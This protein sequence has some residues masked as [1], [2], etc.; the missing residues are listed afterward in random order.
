MESI[1]EPSKSIAE[2]YR[3]LRIV[4]NDGKVYVGRPVLGGDYRS[5]TLRLAVDPQHPFQVTEIDKRTIEEQQV[6]AISFMPEGL[7]DTLSA[8]EIRDLIAFIES[9]GRP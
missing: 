1:V 3:S 4:T 5:Q 7:L 9:G 2:N 6:S 8:D